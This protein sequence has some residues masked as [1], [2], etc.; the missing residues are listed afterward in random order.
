[1]TVGVGLFKYFALMG[2]FPLPPPH[3]SFVNMISVKSDPW[4]IPALDLVDTWGE[5]MLLSPA[6]VNHMEI[7]ST[8]NSASFDSFI[9]KTTFDM[10]SQSL[11]LGTLESPDPLAKTFLADEGIMEVMYL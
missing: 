1:M 2:I 11:W 5:V 7:V 3:V 9:S 4:V 10:Y 8:S 6:E